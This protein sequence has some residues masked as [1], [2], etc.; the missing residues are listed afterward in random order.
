M[1]YKDHKTVQ[2]VEAQIYTVHTMI[3]AMSEAAEVGVDVRMM[4]W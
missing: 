1:A 3:A 2:N 4:L